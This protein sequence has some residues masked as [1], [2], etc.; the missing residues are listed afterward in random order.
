MDQALVQDVVSEVI[1]RLG[2]RT[3]V[4]ARTDMPRA[5]QW[6]RRDG[7]VRAGE[8]ATANEPKQREAEAHPHR[9]SGRTG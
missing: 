2:T 8:D 5:S 1:K 4:G 7:G 6:P 3:P 9:V